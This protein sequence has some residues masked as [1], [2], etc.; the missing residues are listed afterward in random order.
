MY[1]DTSERDDQI[2]EKEE[3]IIKK[4]AMFDCAFSERNIIV[5]SQEIL[6]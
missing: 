6:E 4:S 2:N 3:K 5:K 1:I